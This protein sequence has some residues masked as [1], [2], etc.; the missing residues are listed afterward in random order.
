MGLTK[1]WWQIQGS[2]TLVKCSTKLTVS[3]SHCDYLLLLIPDS[4]VAH[5][6]I[7]SWLDDYDGFMIDSLD[8]IVT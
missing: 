3:T 7:E 4:V 8:A 6:W 1:F 2:I 5:N